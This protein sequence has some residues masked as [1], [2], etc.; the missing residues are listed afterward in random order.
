MAGPT[1]G[2]GTAIL[3]IVV[4][5]SSLYL[6]VGVADLIHFAFMKDKIGR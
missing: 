5:S 3:I 4:L 2:F 6:V 1:V